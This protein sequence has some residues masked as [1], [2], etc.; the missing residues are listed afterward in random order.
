MQESV[1][2]EL[3]EPGQIKP[4][5]LIQAESTIKEVETFIQQNSNLDVI[6]IDR[7]AKA[8][9]MMK[10]TMEGGNPESV[11]SE[12]NSLGSLLQECKNSLTDGGNKKPVQGSDP[13]DA[14]DALD[15]ARQT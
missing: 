2:I 7:L 5:L 3:G 11:K 4:E 6:L 1:P 15:A 13:K 14:K 10:K 12:L 8:G 9:A